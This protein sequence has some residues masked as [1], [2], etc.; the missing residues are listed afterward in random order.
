MRTESQLKRYTLYQ[1][2]NSNPGIFNIYAFLLNSLF[3]LYL[4]IWNWFFFYFICTCVLSCI[5]YFTTHNFWVALV[6]LIILRLINGFTADKVSLNY[7]KK[8]IERNQDVNY[9]RPIIFFPIMARRFFI[10]NILSGGLYQFYWMFQNW[11]AIKKDVKDTQIHP[12]WQSW[13]MGIFFIY[14]LINIILIC[15]KKNKT[16]GKNLPKIAYSYIVC[17]FGMIALFW[18]LSLFKLPILAYYICSFLYFS[19][20]LIG[21]LLLAMVQKRI[22]FYN[23]KKNPKLI[24]NKGYQNGGIVVISIGF[25]ILSALLTY[26]FI[27]QKDN[28]KLTEAVTSVYQMSEGYSR[29]CQKQGYE[30]KKFPQIYKDYFRAEINAIRSYLNA[31]EISLEDAY[32][33]LPT[34]TLNRIDEMILKDMNELKPMIIEMIISRKYHTLAQEDFDIQ[35]ART[36]LEKELTFPVICSEMDLNAYSIINKNKRYKEYFRKTVQDIQKIQ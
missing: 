25:V 28:K 2:E 21:S 13:I 22:N 26:Y 16:S 1:K 10:Y 29:F 33:K 31:E 20:N 17:L 12:F 27:P 18:C 30:M 4:N 32:D 7:I 15:L 3:Y 9:S 6:P 35:D 8:F 23:R 14:P 36:F 5:A 34:E 24:M 11:K 19:F